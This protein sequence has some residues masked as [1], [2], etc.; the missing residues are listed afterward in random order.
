MERYPEM[1]FGTRL[2]LCTNPYCLQ[3]YHYSMVCPEPTTPSPEIRE[4]LK[5]DYR[6]RAKFARMWRDGEFDLGRTP[7]YMRQRAE[8]QAET[9]RTPG[10]G[11][12]WLLVLGPAM[13]LVAVVMG[14]LILYL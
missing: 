12:T 6:M 3:R 10:P 14:A 4:V 1:G 11:Y 13:L 7:S 8:K 5:A 9:A 2:Y